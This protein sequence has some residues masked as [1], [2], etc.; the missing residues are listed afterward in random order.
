M[1]LTFAIIKP[2]AVANGHTGK[3]IDRIIQEK[4]IIRGLKQV[5]MTQTVAEAFYEVH[6]ERPFFSDL[7]RF[8]SSGKSI[9][10]VLEKENAVN[11]WRELIGATNPLQADANTIRKL[12]AENMSKNAVH[13]SDSAEN[14]QKEIAFF[15]T[16]QDIIT[17][18]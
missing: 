1:S 12:F 5:K 17:N 7:T 11:A 14:A 3:I 4:F 9:V 15:F 18:G 10:L 2:D 8:M 6:R 16:N 13:G